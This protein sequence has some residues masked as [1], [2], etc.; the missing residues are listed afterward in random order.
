MI[1]CYT[2]FHYGQ[3]LSNPATLR[4]IPRQRKC[5][6]PNNMHIPPHLPILRQGTEKRRLSDPAPFR[7]LV[8][9]LRSM[10]KKKIWVAPILFVFLSLPCVV[11]THSCA[12]VFS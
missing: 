11:E 7:F 3:S 5:R 6:P 9:A 8:G 1:P 2:G 10:C 4:N 12:A